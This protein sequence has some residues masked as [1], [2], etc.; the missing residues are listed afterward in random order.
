MLSLFILAPLFLLLVLNLPVNFVRKAAFVL[1]SVLLIL[2]VFLALF[3]PFLPWGASR[4]FLGLFFVFNL[5]IDSLTLIMLLT[6][7]IVA[8]VSL[9]VA[10]N[11]ITEAR[12]RFYFINLLLI[13]VIGMNT[14]VLA[15]DIFSLYVFIEITSVA[16]YILISLDRNN[17][18]AI[19]GTF[20]YFILS[21]IATIFILLAIAFFLLAAGDLSFGAI[22]KAFYNSGNALILKIASSL[23]L[24]GLFIKSGV[25]PFHGW[26]ADAYCAA[27][28]CVSV[29]LAGIVTKVA[30]VYVLLRL[31][32]S[33]FVL[34]PAL[35]NIFLFMGAFSIVLAALAALTQDDFKRMLAYSSISQIGYIVLALG[36]ATPL[37]FAGAVLH[38]F[39]H[40]IFKSLLFV[41]SAVLEKQFGSTDM[42][43]LAGFGPKPSLT[44]FTSLTGLL[45]T[46]GIPPLSGFWSKLIIIIALLGSGRWVYAAVALL[47][48][49]L[50]LAYF[51]SF[52]RR[53]FFIKTGSLVPA[54]STLEPAGKVPFGLRVSEISLCI[55]TALAGVG[56]IFVYNHWLPPLEAIF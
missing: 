46:A 21:A 20:K 43:K 42:N 15:R 49:V 53:V 13:C 52:Q 50:T 10:R 41:N 24:C 2:Q 12:Q 7:G 9:V 8:F 5:A 44:N 16:S 39:N 30:G 31:F 29:L 27:P 18:V 19:E 4:D 51:L 34:N 14:I 3:Y 36:C 47:A 55:I 6:I 35:Q 54:Q 28:A 32:G 38:F 37:A 26:V 45:S 23:F 1:A 11:T 25:A 33:V 17:K 40:A 22:H 48:S 56:L